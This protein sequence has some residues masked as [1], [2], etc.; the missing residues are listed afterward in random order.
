MRVILTDEERAALVAAQ[1]SSRDGARCI[2]L[3]IAELLER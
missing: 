3:S 2:A 1:R